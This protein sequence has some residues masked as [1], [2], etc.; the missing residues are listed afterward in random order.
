MEEINE[1]K[2]YYNA[3]RQEREKAEGEI[4]EVTSSLATVFGK[5]ITQFTLSFLAF[6]QTVSCDTPKLR[7]EREGTGRP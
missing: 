2:G 4:K 7:A 5:K 1:V 6:V 3:E